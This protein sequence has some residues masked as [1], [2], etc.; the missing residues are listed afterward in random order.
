MTNTL[1]SPRLV[2]VTQGALGQHGVWT[3]RCHCLHPQISLLHLIPA[4]LPA[5]SVSEAASTWEM[6]GR[7][8]QIAWVQIT[9]PLDTP[10]KLS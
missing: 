10:L 8:L 6:L 9:V 2:M 3:L 5:A 1:S 7:R 4:A